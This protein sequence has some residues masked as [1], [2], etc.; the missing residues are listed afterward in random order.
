MVIEVIGALVRELFE[1][2]GIGIHLIS[3][4]ILNAIAL[5]RID[6]A[7]GRT[8]FRESESLQ[9]VLSH[10]LVEIE[11]DASQETFQ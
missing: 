9:I 4:I 5:E 8:Y 6:R 1:Y 11:S 7:L 2:Q 3:P 10:A